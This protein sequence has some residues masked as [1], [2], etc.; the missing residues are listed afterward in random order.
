MQEWYSSEALEHFDGAIIE[1]PKNTRSRKL[2]KSRMQY[3]R[4]PENIDD[5]DLEELGGLH[6]QNALVKQASLSQGPQ[7]YKFE[8]LAELIAQNED[9][10]EFSDLNSDTSEE[11]D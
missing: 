10:I 4:E 2:R 3:I 11:G 6:A 9:D 7:T 5:E 1:S 8:H